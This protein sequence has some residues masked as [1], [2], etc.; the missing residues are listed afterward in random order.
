MRNRNPLPARPRYYQER[1]IDWYN[2]F[3]TVGAFCAHYGLGYYEAI[4]I[5]KKVRFDF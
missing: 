4:K 2:N 3:G 1:F 5:I